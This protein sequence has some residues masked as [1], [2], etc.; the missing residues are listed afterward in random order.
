MLLFLHTSPA[1]GFVLT[2]VTNLLQQQNIEFGTDELRYNLFDLR[3]SLRNLRIRSHEAPDLPPFASIARVSLDLSLSQVLRR[4]YVL[5]SGDVEGVAVHYFVDANGRDN[6]PRPPTD[7]NQPSQPLDYLIEELQV[8]AAKVRY[9]NVPQRIDVTIPVSS[10][11][12][13]GDAL[14]DRHTVS[15]EAADGT[16]I[17]QDRRAALDKLSGELDLGDDDVRVER[18]DVVA[19]GAD[20]TLT[21]HVAQFA[22]PQGDLALRGTVDAARASAVAA[23]PDPVSGAFRF[24]ATA[25]GHLATP[26]VNAQ[27]SGT[28]VTFRTLSDIAVKT[29]A[30]FDTGTRRLSFS[31]LEVLAPFGQVVGSGAVSLAG[32]D[33]SRINATVT[34]LDAATLMRAFETPYVVASRVEARVQAQWPGLEYVEAS[35][36]ATATLSPTAPR[37]SR[38]VIPVGGRLDVEGS[39]RTVDAVLSRVTAGGAE[40]NGRVRLTDQRDLDGTA[41]LRVADVAQSVAVAEAVLGEPRGSLLPTP[42]AGAIDG[43]ARIGGSLSAPTV[44]ADLRAPSLA[45]GEASGLAVDTSVSYSP[46]MVD[47]HGFNLTWQQATAQA[48]GTVALTGA[49]RL[50]LKFKGDALEVA[51]LLR[52]V[53]QSAVPA[54]GTLSFQG[55]V[56]GTAT[57]PAVAVTLTGANLVAYDEQWGALGARIDMSGRQLMVSELMLDKPQPEGNGR[58][59]GSG[60]YHLDR[61]TYTVD[62]QSENIQLLTLALPDGQQVRGT[63]EFSAKG[64][65]AVDQPAGTIKLAADSLVVDNYTI[66]RIVADAVLANRQSTITAVVPNYGITANAMIGVDRP[67]ATTAKVRV[68]DLQ[69]ATLPLKLETRLE[70]TLRA[71]ADA[72]GNLE[73]PESIQATAIVE[74]FSGSWNEQ[75]FSVD[76]PAEFG[77]RNERLAIE[78]LRLV[79]QDS[80]IAVRGELPLTERGAPGAINLDARANLATLAQYAPAGTNITGAGELTVTGLIRGTLG[81]IDPELTFLVANGSVVTPDIA[82]GP[83]RHQYPRPGCWRC[84]SHWNS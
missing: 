67:F 2:Q 54:S 62:L 26:V 75:P 59:T 83:Q 34:G 19:E 74:A 52:V 14:T 69:L 13:E 11:T 6:L 56:S 63:L 84:R 58:L 55:R 68:D 21:G 64:D 47:L 30:T 42:V 16:L 7:P 41:R 32:T 37:A 51:E 1:R 70:G 4:R 57:Q 44:A 76:A 46:A 23:L 50:D 53:N 40:V 81:A 8:R 31:D 45:V 78:Q 43:T 15:L 33:I 29:T 36:T 25:K 12:V 3:L 27:V 5:Q 24:E 61:Q 28:D 77:Y 38:S 48:T 35:G 71:A 65:G 49:R 82:P 18:I 79:A 22:D 66:G 9:E 17:F 39:G 60:N 20:L 10:M 80:T 72:S 73:T